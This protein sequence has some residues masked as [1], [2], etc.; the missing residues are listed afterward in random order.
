ML[1]AYKRIAATSF[2]PAAVDPNL[3]T[4][5]TRYVRPISNGATIVPT[6]VCVVVKVVEF[7]VNISVATR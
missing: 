7:D 2:A 1:P 6:T 4:T 5:L 3:V